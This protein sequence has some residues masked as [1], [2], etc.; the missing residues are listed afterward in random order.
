M[1]QGKRPSKKQIRVGHSINEFCL[2]EK[3]PSSAVGFNNVVLTEQ[4]SQYSL[5][6]L[7]FILEVLVLRGFFKCNNLVFFDSY[8]QLDP[9][10]TQ[11]L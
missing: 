9:I 3:Q 2:P 10:L 7:A 1:E 11:R 5:N 4:V 6:C 8:S